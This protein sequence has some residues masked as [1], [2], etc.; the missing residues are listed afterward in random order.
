MRR[1]VR[2]L[3][4][5]LAAA[6]LG[7]AV[8]GCGG[9]TAAPTASAWPSGPSSVSADITGVVRDL[10]PGGNAGAV[11]MLVV[12]DPDVASPVDRAWVRVASTTVVWAPAG[13]GRTQLTVDDLAEGQRVAVQFVGPIAESYPVQ[14]TAGDVEILT[15]QK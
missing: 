12:A 6:A 4:A 10:T 8:V 14:A 9:G 13:E 15:P 5:L 1:T 7:A 3:A 11:T 2:A